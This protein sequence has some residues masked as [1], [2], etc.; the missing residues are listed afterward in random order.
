MAIKPFKVLTALA[1]AL[2][3]LVSGVTSEARFPRGTPTI[4]G[5][6]GGNSQVNLNGTEFGYDYIFLNQLKNAGAWGLFD[7][8]GNPSPADLDANQ[9]PLAG[10]DPFVNHSGVVT[11]VQVPRASHASTIYATRTTGKCTLFGFGTILTTAT[12]P[13]P[14]TIASI[15]GSTTT[16]TINF[17]GAHMFTVGMEVPMSGVSGTIAATLNGNT[18]VVASVATNSIT[19][20]T[21]GANGLTGSGGTATYGSK[22]IGVATGGRFIS[23]VDVGL[24]G[25]ANGD[26]ISVT[27]AMFAQ[28]ATTPCT[29]IAMVRVGSEE[30]RYNAGEIFGADFLAKMTQAKFG[31]IRHLNTMNTNLSNIVNWADRTP[32]TAFSYGTYQLKSS[33]YAG[34]ASGKGLDYT[35]TLGAATLV[36]KRQ[37]TLAFPKQSATISVASP[38]VITSTA[39]GLQVGDMFNI[40]YDDTA[41]TGLTPYSGGTVTYYVIAAGFGANSFQYS[42]TQGGSAINVTGAGVGNFYIQKTTLDIDVTF[43]TGTGVIT[44]AQNHMLSINDPI[45]CGDRSGSTMP[46]NLNKYGGIY[47]V[48]TVPTATTITISATPGGTA[49]GSFTGSPSGSNYCIRLP[50]YNLNGTGARPIL[51]NNAGA[52]SYAGGSIP[53]ARTFG[54]NNAYGTMTYDSI[55]G[56]WLLFGAADAWQTMGIGSYWPPEIAFALSVKLGAHPQFP[57]PAYAIN[58]ETV[59]DF[60]PSLAYYLYTNQP[61]WMIPRIDIKNEQ[62]NGQFMGSFRDESL[63]NKL[64]FDGTWSAP[65]GTLEMC[66]REGSLLGQALQQIY[67]GTV[68]GSGS[69]RYET[70]INVQTGTMLSAGAANAQDA[71]LTAAQFVAQA[72]AAPA[73][74]SVSGFGT[75][76]FAKNAAYKTVTHVDP[77]NY[78]RSAPGATENGYASTFNGKVFVGSISGT[79]LTVPASVPG[80]TFGSLA[81]GDVVFGNGIPG[82]AG[83]VT[84][85]GAGGAYPQTW[86]LSQNLGTQPSR[87][88]YAG[89]S[90]TPV[91]D[92]VDLMAGTADS[93]NLANLVIMYGVVSNWAKQSKFNDDSGAVKRMSGYEG[94][95]SPDYDVRGTVNNTLDALRH[96]GKFVT[97]STLYPTGLQG[98][99][100]QNYD[101]FVAAGGEFPSMFTFTGYYPSGDVWSVLEDLYQTGPSPQLKAACQF[102]GTTC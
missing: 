31:V 18:F 56:A 48:K 71:K 68:G 34:A 3:Y 21:S 43:N 19:I 33:I 1:V 7:G 90:W 89:T 73:S 59:G 97:T 75:V 38:S 37:V 45:S 51:A 58:G 47:Y 4:S 25:Q 46:T 29:D 27:V 26:A 62:W 69:K 60:M 14:I 40:F 41:P 12:Q 83:T 53:R 55:M 72:P 85:S 67:G 99:L 76:T 84:I 80:V 30:T 81:N 9:L 92:Y 91:R 66:G 63:A 23:D 82:S 50:T 17:S 54:R 57:A 61:A 15:S 100:K 10:S 86:T 22:T 42:L 64:T 52:L 24:G 39:H 65:G 44:W 16:T 28:D 8:K 98:I 5:F 102:N 32:L 2:L 70:H 77:A 6:N 35:G 11:T 88:L 93:F 96:A 20:T 101:S 78:M 36:D 95:Y 74:V 87:T 49:I 94:G 13:S 79:T